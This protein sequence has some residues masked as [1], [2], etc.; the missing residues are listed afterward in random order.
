MKTN[1]G[2]VYKSIEEY[3]KE[4]GIR[5]DITP[6][7]SGNFYELFLGSEPG[8]IQVEVDPNDPDEGDVFFQ[9]FSKVNDQGNSI[10][11]DQWD[12][13]NKNFDLIGCIDELIAKIK[14]LNKAITRIGYKIED[15]KSICEE[16]EMDFEEFILIVYDFEGE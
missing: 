10:Y 5:Y 4:Q 11:H 9:F 6:D 16:N 3:L 8:F 7:P 13:F 1:K 2:N 12:T 14:A 15:I